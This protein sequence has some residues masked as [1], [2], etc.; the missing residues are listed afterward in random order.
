VTTGTQKDSL[1]VKMNKHPHG[2]S[3]LPESE[4]GDALFSLTALQ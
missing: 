2:R 1:F 4:R 3:G